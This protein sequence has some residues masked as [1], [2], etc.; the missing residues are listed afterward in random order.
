MPA[1][2]PVKKVCHKCGRD[3]AGKPREKDHLG[4]Y[5]CIACSEADKL[6]QLHIESGICEGCGESPGRAALLLIGGQNLCAACRTR[7]YKYGLDKAKDNSGGLL[8]SIKK[9]LFGR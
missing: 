9:S 3:L 4:Q 1:Q 2:T 5:W 7:K 6:H 8:G